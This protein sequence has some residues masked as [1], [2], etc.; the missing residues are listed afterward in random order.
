[1][2]HL[3]V[4]LFGEGVDEAV[5]LGQVVGYISASL[6]LAAPS[7]DCPLYVSVD[8]R[9][10]HACRLQAVLKAF[11]LR[12]VETGSMDPWRTRWTRLRSTML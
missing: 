8:L 11:L 2:G 3:A 9:R 5:H 1:M 10:A 4:E 12:R 7:S 6:E